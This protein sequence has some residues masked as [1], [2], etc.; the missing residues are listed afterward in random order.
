MCQNGK[1]VDA[2]DFFQK[3]LDIEM[4]RFG[5]ISISDIRD[6]P[7]RVISKGELWVYTGDDYIIIC[8]EP[9]PRPEQVYILYKFVVDLRNNPDRVGELVELYD[10]P[11]K[12]AYN[13]SESYK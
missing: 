13:E 5:I 2:I 1:V 7:N 6:Q 12:G 3:K 4:K 9:I 11:Y 10:G 8:R